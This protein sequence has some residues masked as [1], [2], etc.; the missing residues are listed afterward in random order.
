MRTNHLASV[1]A[2]VAGVLL[3]SPARADADVAGVYDVTFEEVSTNCTSPLRYAPG[4]LEVKVKGKTA[5]VDIART[6]LMHGSTGKSG[7]LS[8][9]SKR[10]R[11]M[12]DGMDGVFSIAGKIAP[13]GTVELV[14]IGE[15]TASGRALCSQSW[16][17]RGAKAGAGKAQGKQAVTGVDVAA[18]SALPAILR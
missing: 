17:V 18:W 12:L 10:G 5:T 2:G 1:L 16:N 13:D 3:A 14:M 6:P 9:K 7:K 8:A 4:K 15:Y 11:T